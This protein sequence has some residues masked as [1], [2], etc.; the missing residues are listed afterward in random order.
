M[1]SR[2]INKVILIGHLRHD[3]EV[4]YTPAGNAVTNL[5]LATSDTWRDKT[6]GEH[7]ETTEWH[8]IVLFG[9]VGE[10]AGQYL[11]K[12]SF[13]YIEGQLRTR[14][15]QDQ[16]GQDKYTTEIIVNSTGTLHMLNKRDT[17]GDIDQPPHTSHSSERVETPFT[18][19]VQPSSFDDDIPF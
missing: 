4:R 8:R 17:S 2:G 18:E 5:T 12:G 15:W 13:I 9:K 19:N 6:T 11:R 10:I 3:P 7:K 14:K 1:A 16:N